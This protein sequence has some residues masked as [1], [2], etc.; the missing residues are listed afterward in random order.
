MR[1][2][3][4]LVRLAI[5]PHVRLLSVARQVLTATPEA[6]GASMPA[7]PSVGVLPPME[8]CHRH[9]NDQ[10]PAHESVMPPHLPTPTPTPPIPPLPVRRTFPAHP[11]SVPRARRAVLDALPRPHHPRLR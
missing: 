11:L 5:L 9:F 10:P 6:H 3:D 4:F 7:H 8:T 1:G 2:A